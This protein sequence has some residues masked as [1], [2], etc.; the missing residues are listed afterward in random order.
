MEAGR[1]LLLSA[2]G[3][4]EAALQ[5]QLANIQELWKEACSRLEEQRRRLA[6]VLKVS[7]LC[8]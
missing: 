6:G 5:A 3:A 1:Q 8:C 2:D 4:A 7:P